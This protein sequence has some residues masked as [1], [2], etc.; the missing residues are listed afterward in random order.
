MENETL[1]VIVVTSEFRDL[2]ASMDFTQMSDDQFM[3]WLL[4][5]AT[6]EIDPNLL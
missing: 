1:P 3:K 2:V 6:A 4:S 5:H